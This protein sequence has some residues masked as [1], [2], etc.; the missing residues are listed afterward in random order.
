MDKAD[1]EKLLETAKVDPKARAEQLGLDDWHRLTKTY[2][3]L[4]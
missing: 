4:I 1:I 2:V 3:S